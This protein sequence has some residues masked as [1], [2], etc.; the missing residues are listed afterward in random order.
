MLIITSELRWILIHRREV[1]PQHADSVVCLMNGTMHSHATHHSAWMCQEPPWSSIH[2]KPAWKSLRAPNI[3]HHAE[4]VTNVPRTN[5]SI[6][7]RTTLMRKHDVRPP[8]NGSSK[9]R[10]SPS[11]PPTCTPMRIVVW[12]NG[13][14]HAGYACTHTQHEDPSKTLLYVGTCKITVKAETIITL[15]LW[16]KRLHKIIL[17]VSISWNMIHDTAEELARLAKL[18]LK[19]KREGV[20][21]ST[22]RWWG[23]ERRR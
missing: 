14:P 4:Q 3:A 2:E 7:I 9:Q 8:Q 6:N 13:K 23:G 1:W 17:A 22:K 10:L 5:S 21:H 20:K 19:T 18:W 11:S 15:M 16:N 12:T